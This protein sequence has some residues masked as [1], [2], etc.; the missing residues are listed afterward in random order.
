MMMLICALW[1][2]HVSAVGFTEKKLPETLN[3]KA[4]AYY[5]FWNTVKHF[6]KL[7]SPPTFLCLTYFFDRQPKFQKHE[8]NV[9]HLF[10][11]F[12]CVSSFL[13]FFFAAVSPLGFIKFFT[14]K[15]FYWPTVLFNAFFMQIVWLW[16]AGLSYLIFRKRFNS[17]QSV[18][19]SVLTILSAELIWEF[20]INI[21][22]GSFT[23]FPVT[24]FTMYLARLIPLYLLLAYGI[25]HKIGKPHYFPFIWIPGF[26]SFVI[27]FFGVSP[28][29]PPFWNPSYFRAVWGSSFLAYAYLLTKGKKR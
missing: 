2:I 16:L 15:T 5:S 19:L 12:I 1:L 14:R 23:S 28:Y 13:L 22:Y 7:L 24:V 17:Y 3:P 18:F 21:R 8:K 9:N 10:L 20:P 6:F 11:G 4:P 29:C 27:L 26:V 25:I